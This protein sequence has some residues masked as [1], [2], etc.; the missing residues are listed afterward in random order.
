MTRHAKKD[1]TTV[2]KDTRGR[3]V[4]NESTTS[5]LSRNEATDTLG[6]EGPFETF[7]NMSPKDL[8]PAMLERSGWERK[9]MQ[10][11]GVEMR[12]VFD[13]AKRIDV[14]RF[15][16]SGNISRTTFLIDGSAVS[17]NQSMPSIVDGMALED[18]Y[19]LPCQR[20][21]YEDG[22]LLGTD[23]WDNDV[24]VTERRYENGASSRYAEYVNGSLIQPPIRSSSKG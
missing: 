8:T 12:K 6:T 7:K 9:E 3:I 11:G 23:Y 1:G 19:G 14:V 22:A 24:F 5:R 18:R 17:S 21:F 16:A 13:G 20:V 15:Y 2:I 4:D 10:G